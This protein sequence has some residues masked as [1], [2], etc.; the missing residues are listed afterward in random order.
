MDKFWKWTNMKVNTIDMFSKP[1]SLTYQKKEKFTTF[2]GGMIT[3]ILI[4]GLIAY[5]IQLSIQMFTRS[6]T[7]MS[8]NV[9]KRDQILVTDYYNLGDE[10][11]KF[12][13]YVV[14]DNKVS[15]FT[16]PTY[17][18]LSAYQFDYSGDFE[19]SSLAFNITEVGMDICGENFPRASEEIN[20]FRK[21]ISNFTYCPVSSN[22]SVG[23]SLL[24]NQV[25]LVKVQIKKCINGTSII[26]KPDSEIE[27]KA[28]NIDVTI[29]VSSKYLDFDDYDTPIKQIIDDKFYFRMS[30][31]MR[32]YGRLDVKKSTVSLS[33]SIFPFSPE[34]QQSF[35]SIDNYRQDGEMRYDGD[36]LLMDFEFRQDPTVDSYERRVY[37]ILDLFG[38]LGGFF[39]VLAI[40]GGALVHYFASQM[41]SYSLFT[42]LYCLNETDAHI[43]SDESQ[44]APKPSKKE[45]DTIT[46]KLNEKEKTLLQTIE[47]RI[48]SKRRFHF[49]AK[50]YFKTL[51]PCFKT[52]SRSEFTIL[53]DKLSDE[54]DLTSVVCSIRHLKTLMKLTLSEH[55]ALMMDFNCRSNYLHKETK[56]GCFTKPNDF[57]PPTQEP[58]LKIKTKSTIL[59]EKLK[60]LDYDT[61][62]RDASIFLGIPFE[63]QTSEEGVQSSSLFDRDKTHKKNKEESIVGFFEE[64]KDNSNLHKESEV[65][66]DR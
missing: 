60:N 51:V 4:L 3:G 37:S 55:Q 24:L 57:P 26:C 56:D 14:D 19:S 64:E 32:K 63:Y 18:N 15:G 21:Y 36:P 5:G 61:L 12:A 8:K 52:R 54:C 10:E 53:S 7:S 45:K 62:E 65:Y 20:E 16:D 48:N 58:S 41:Y 1:V 28:R 27:A 44:I 23:G 22:F 50:D 38:Q 40:F 6:A 59:M 42:H 43:T 39:E 66:K 11:L 25:K 31:G 2:F 17:F 47:S 33:D 29:I 34:K 35:L 9:I 46:T 49:T 30:S 13:V